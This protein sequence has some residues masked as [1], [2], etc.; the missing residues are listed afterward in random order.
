MSS[1]IRICLV[2]ATGLVG[3]TLIEQALHRSEFRIIGVARREVPLPFGARMEMLIADPAGWADAIAAARAKVLVCALGTTMR[4]VG[5]DEAAF[6]AVDYDLVIE[7]ARAAQ[8]AGIRHLIVVSSAGADRASRHFYLR[9]KG[10]L[11]QELGRMRFQRL[12]I[13]RPALLRGHRAESRPL[14][15]LGRALAPLADP[16]LWGKWRAY[17]S[18]RAEMLA[19]TIFALAK[20]KAGGQFV[21]D[22]DAMRRAIRR[23]ADKA[24]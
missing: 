10:E 9:V 13:L 15:S 5:K 18:V 2:G 8:Q 7:S 21:H 24:R 23:E 20:E 14:E 12:D 11:E 6:R 16:F 4:K 17:H 3:T 22:Y 19:Q 1:Q